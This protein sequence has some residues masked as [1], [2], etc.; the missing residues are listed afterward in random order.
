MTLVSNE[1]KF[2]GTYYAIHTF[3]VE[4]QPKSL[5][6]CYFVLIWLQSQKK[7]EILKYSCKDLFILAEVPIA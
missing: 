7:R 6:F 4:G 5:E 3:C 2:T 1:E